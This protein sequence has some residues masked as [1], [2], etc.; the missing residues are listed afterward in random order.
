VFLEPCRYEK[1]FLEVGKLVTSNTYSPLPQLTH[2]NLT[3][4]QNIAVKYGLNLYPPAYFDYRLYQA[5]CELIKELGCFVS[6]PCP[7]NLTKIV[8]LYS[9]KQIIQ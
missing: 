1:L 4:L 7:F 3:W 9:P 2:E 5:I 8:T 6:Y